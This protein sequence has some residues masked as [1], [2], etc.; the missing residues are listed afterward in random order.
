MF[1]QDG[2]IFDS[3][4][5]SRGNSAFLVAQI[6][7]SSGDE[8]AWLWIDPDL[9]AEPSKSLAINGL[10]GSSV[11]DFEFD[12][13]GVY[14]DRNNNGFADEMRIATTFAEVATYTAVPEPSTLGS[15]LTSLILLVRYRKRRKT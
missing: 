3:G 1:D 14:F 12:K 6:D 15:A 4:V 9:N 11:K 10:A 13:I 2:L 8:T 7:F 5:S